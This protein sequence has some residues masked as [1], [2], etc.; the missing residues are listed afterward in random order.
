MTHAVK[1]YH[2]VR[3]TDGSMQHMYTQNVWNLFWNMN[4]Q[5]GNSEAVSTV[6]FSS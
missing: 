3:E 2:D 5:K 4:E 1:F 6:I